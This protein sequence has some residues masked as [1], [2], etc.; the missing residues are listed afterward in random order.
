MLF[1]GQG[2][3]AS[4]LSKPTG[5]TLVRKRPDMTEKSVDWDEKPQPK[6]TNLTKNSLIFL[7]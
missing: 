6:Q 7:L 2:T 1:L 5:S 3:S 4:L